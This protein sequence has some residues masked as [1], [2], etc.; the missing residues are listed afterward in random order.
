MTLTSY[1]QHRELGDVRW[2]RLLA[3]AKA[4]ARAENKP[5]LLLFQ[6]VP[7]CMTCV[8]YGQNVLSDPLLVEAIEGFFVPVVI[9]NNHK[10]PDEEALRSF[11]ETAWN[12]PVV[13]F[14]S[15]DGDDL[16]LRVSNTYDAISLHA[17]MM[18]AIKAT[19]G[20]VP[21]YL[22]VVGDDLTVQCGGARKLTFET[23][24]FWSGET[25][26]AQHPGILT[27]DAG[28]I[29]GEEVVEVQ[30][31]PARVSED[32]LKAF[33][34]QEGFARSDEAE[35]RL[36]KEPQFYLRKTD[37]RYLPLSPVQRTKLNFALPY[38]QSPEAYLSPRQLEAL[39]SGT[40]KASENAELYR[41]DID[42]SW[43][44][45]SSKAAA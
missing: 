29:A 25:S 14:L 31:D 19:G 39:K 22:R 23:P 24:C 42:R 18:R 15:P 34:A 30:Y 10:G 1:K 43:G 7:G 38:R 28:W 9:F 26:L 36:D 33:A 27:T 2:F 11:H 37:Y 4:K 35:F 3:D 13:R 20:V 41:E 8:N 45:L 16:N 5:I 44:R 40:L 21:T 6:E 32:E 17:A 12:N